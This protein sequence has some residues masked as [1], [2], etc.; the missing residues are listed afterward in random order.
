MTEKDIIIA[1]GDEKE[2]VKEE[3]PPEQ[4]LE[5][6]PGEQDA[7]APKQAEEKKELSPVAVGYT[8]GVRENGEFVFEVK[9]SKPGLV[10]LL[11]VH[12]FAGRKIDLLYDRAQVEGQAAV[13]VQFQQLSQRVQSL[14]GSL[15]DVLNTLVVS[16]AS[17][18][19]E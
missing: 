4:P 12:T 16:N 7:V 6:K 10:E 3:A 11:G 1:D 18:K 13:A 17:K 2:A 8:V 9:G 15:K 14:A 5:T 19:E